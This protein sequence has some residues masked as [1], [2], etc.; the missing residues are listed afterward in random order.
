MLRG[1]NGNAP[2]APT[3]PTDG[4]EA[5]AVA[6]APALGVIR[7]NC[8]VNGGGSVKAASA[9]TKEAVAAPTKEAAGGGAAEVGASS[10]WAACHKMARRDVSA[11]PAGEEGST[12][13]PTADKA[14]SKT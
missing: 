14:R 7:G 2:V 1:P 12:G 10:A 11:W 9:P 4:G 5:A 6:A 3:A 8:N 13:A